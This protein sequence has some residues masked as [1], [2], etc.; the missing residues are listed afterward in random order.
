MTGLPPARRRRPLP[1]VACGSG[2]PGRSRPFEQNMSVTSKRQGRE[3]R[4]APWPASRDVQKLRGVTAGRD[5]HLIRTGGTPVLGPDMAIYPFRHHTRTHLGSGWKPRTTVRRCAV[6]SGR[7]ESSYRDGAG[8]SGQHSAGL[9]RRAG[10]H[11]FRLGLCAWNDRTSVAGRCFPRS[12]KSVPPEISARPTVRPS[13]ERPAAA[14][15]AGLPCGEARCLPVQTRLGPS[16]GRAAFF[17]E[18]RG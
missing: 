17:R 9:W 15:R 4:G 13:S 3:A 12:G 16:R 14:R 2:S 6:Q 8:R 5:R 7:P 11:R 1:S 18:V 10:A